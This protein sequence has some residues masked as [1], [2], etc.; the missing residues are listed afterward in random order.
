MKIET[1]AIHAAA[2]P[3][4]VTGAISPPIYLS[5]TFEHGPGCEELHGYMYVRD[6]NPTK[7]A[8]KKPSVSWRAG[9]GAHVYSLEWE[10]PSRCC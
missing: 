9:E 3:D 1:L 8:L 2:D 7:T 6:K 5:R 10:Q 4:P